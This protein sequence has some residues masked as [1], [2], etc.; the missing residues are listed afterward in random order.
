MHSNT[1]AILSDRAATVELKASLVKPHSAEEPSPGQST[2]IRK[3]MRMDVTALIPE[4][5]LF[6]SPL[7]KK[8]NGQVPK[9]LTSINHFIVL[10]KNFIQQ[11][12]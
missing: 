2:E 9:S 10:I 7:S 12:E 11:F 3:D 4:H 5:H 8:H 1:Q 6:F